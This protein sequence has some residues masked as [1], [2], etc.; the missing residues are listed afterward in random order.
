MPE[1]TERY[2]HIPIRN[3]NDFVQASFRT[4]TISK[5]QG[6]LAVI[7]K[8]KSDPRGSTHIQKYMF[9][10]AKGWTMEKARKWVREHRHSFSMD[11][12]DPEYYLAWFVDNELL[13]LSEKIICQ[14]CGAEI[15][16]EDHPEV[17]MGFIKCPSCGVEIDQEGKSG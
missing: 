1:T 9:S 14:N 5:S 13:N 8:L 7:G 11:V 6:I 2:V 12:F 17:R 15:Q 4:I 3:K 10:K 16:W